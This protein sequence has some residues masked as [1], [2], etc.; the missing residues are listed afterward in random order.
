MAAVCT[1]MTKPVPAL[2]PK[3]WQG[4]PVNPQEVI[5]CSSTGIGN[6]WWIL[7][8]YAKTGIHGGFF[9]SNLLKPFRISKTSVQQ[10]EKCKFFLTFCKDSQNLS[11]HK[12]PAASLIL[13]EPVS[14][15]LSVFPAAQKPML[16]QD[17]RAKPW[18][19]LAWCH[20]HQT[21]N[22]FSSP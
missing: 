21:C 1:C 7:C 12:K 6:F 13:G 11:F 10:L 17:L 16:L 14:L 19:S 15:C 22:G 8:A 5:S 9:P 20:T 4:Q 18:I 2:S 3:A